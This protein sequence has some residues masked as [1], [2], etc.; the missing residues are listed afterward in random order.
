MSEHSSGNSSIPTAFYIILAILA[1]LAVGYIFTNPVLS[2]IV[3]L[4]L[5]GAIGFFGAL[6]FG[7]FFG[8]WT[9]YLVRA[10]QEYRQDGIYIMMW[11]VRIL[12][13]VVCG[14]LLALLIG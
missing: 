2:E 14:V 11:G 3:E 9:L 12:T 10:G 6:S 7:L 1:V 5:Y 13:L 8:G 4:L